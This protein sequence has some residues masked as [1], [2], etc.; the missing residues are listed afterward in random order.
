MLSILNELFDLHHNLLFM[1]FI[2][3]TK[4]ENQIGHKQALW[5]GMLKLGRDENKQAS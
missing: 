1:I 5:P 2:F 3:Y 4:K